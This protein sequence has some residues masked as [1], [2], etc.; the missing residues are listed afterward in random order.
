MLVWHDSF[1]SDRSH[2]GSSVEARS[3][4]LL[5]LFRQHLRDLWFRQ[6]PR[7]RAASVWSPAS[8]V[9]GDTVLE[10]VRLVAHDV[11]EEMWRDMIAQLR[12]SSP[13]LRSL[14]VES[15]LPT[16]EAEQMN[17]DV[18]ALSADPRAA[19]IY[20]S[21]LESRV[22][23]LADDPREFGNKVH[24]LW[25]SDVIDLT[26]ALATCELPPYVLSQIIHSIG[27]FFHVPADSDLVEAGLGEKHEIALINSINQSIRRV[28]QDR[29]KQS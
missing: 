6:H 2:A 11:D 27:D 14:I 20:P 13:R 26:L 8:I 29:E 4:D 7:T 16:V 5:P 10:R 15:V 25:H 3:K 28:W 19:Y 17:R 24:Y 23:I 12:H 22:C 21:R 9:A 1:F 18:A